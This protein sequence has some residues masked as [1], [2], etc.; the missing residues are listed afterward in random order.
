MLGFDETICWLTRECWRR[1]SRAGQS[2]LCG[3][4]LLSKLMKEWDEAL[5]HLLRERPDLR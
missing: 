2:Y 4:A 1:L 5:K 3:S